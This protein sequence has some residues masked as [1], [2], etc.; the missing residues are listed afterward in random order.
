MPEVNLIPDPSQVNVVSTLNNPVAVTATSPDVHPN[1][2]VRLKETVV[3]NSNSYYAGR[4][5]ARQIPKNY[6]TPRYIEVI[7]PHQTPNNEYDIN[8]TR[9]SVKLTTEK[10]SP[11]QLAAYGKPPEITVDNSKPPTSPNPLVDSTAS[12]ETKPKC[13]VNQA[14]AVE[15]E[16]LDFVGVSTA[17]KII[18]LRE[19]KPFTDLEDLSKRVPLSGRGSWE[20]LKTQILF[21]PNTPSTKE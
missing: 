13:L 16:A 6:R 10:I 12:S 8:M 3:I 9:Q 7:E 20:D 18:E 21:E 19:T 2:V 15:L 14:T 4:Y 17:T 11:Q 1:A 5:R